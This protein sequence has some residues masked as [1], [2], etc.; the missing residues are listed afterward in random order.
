[1]TDINTD[2]LITCSECETDYNPDE[3][4]TYSMVTEQ[5]VC[6]SCEESDLQYASTV[7][8]V[9]DFVLH[10]FLIGDLFH[11]N[12]YGDPVD[13]GAKRKY[14]STDAWRGYNETE[15]DGLVTVL[16]G[17]TTG[18]WDDSTA[19]RKATFNEWAE[20]ITTGEIVPPFKLAIIVDPTSNVFST[21]ITVQAESRERF[22]K[23]VGEDT[24]EELENALS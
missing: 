9:Q 8:L 12:E 19:R 2:Q 23:W 3:E 5:P 14:V 18:G 15:I 24:F 10:K 16:T 6:H 13:I 4:G 20:S 1:M 17:W 11:I 21:S 22:I 7:H